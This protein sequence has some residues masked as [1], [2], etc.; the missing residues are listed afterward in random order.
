MKILLTVLAYIMLKMYFA[1][2]VMMVA[3]NTI[4][5]PRSKRQQMQPPPYNPNKRMR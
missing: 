1:L 4:F 5:H 3:G 2:S